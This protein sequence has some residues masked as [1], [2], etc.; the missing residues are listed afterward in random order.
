VTFLDL[1]VARDVTHWY[2]I[3]GF[4]VEHGWPMLVLVEEIVL[5]KNCC[6]NGQ[7]SSLD[8]RFQTLIMNGLDKWSLN[9]KFQVKIEYGGTI[10]TPITFLS[11]NKLPWSCYEAQ[12]E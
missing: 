4:N 11:A 9:L 1:L 3:H 7:N 8:P 5:E 2:E 12:E 10:S 6:Q